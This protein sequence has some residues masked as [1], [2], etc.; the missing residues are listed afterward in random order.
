MA[1]LRS[2]IGIIR[3]AGAEPILMTEPP[4]NPAT[5]GATFNAASEYDRRNVNDWTRSLAAELRCALADVDA[6]YATNDV[7]AASA[8][9]LHPI[10]VM[11]S[12]YNGLD[13]I[14]VTLAEALLK[15]SPT[16]YG[17]PH[18]LPTQVGNDD[19]TRADST[20]TLGA[21]WT[22]QRGTWGISA[23]RAYPVTN[24]VWDCATT[25]TITADHAVV[26]DVVG[27]PGAAYEGGVVARYVPGAGFYFADLAVTA[28]RAGVAKL[29]KVTA[30]LAPTLIGAFVAVPGMM[31]DQ[32]TIELGIVG[33]KLT[34]RVNG[35]TLIQATDATYA[36]S[37]CGI[38][39]LAG[40][41]FDN[42]AWYGA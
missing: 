42:F 38:A 40:A 11:A 35:I 21:P 1:N 27:A 5:I 37:K 30:A 24:T 3:W 10:G 32:A 39:Q 20:V 16:V 33:T 9:G 15:T 29:Y 28:G 8:D 34:V 12:G 36:G 22:A 17:W 26:A 2:M 41:K 6:A 7:S 25:D 18:I 13:V 4:I 23:N 31:A 14:C 19:F